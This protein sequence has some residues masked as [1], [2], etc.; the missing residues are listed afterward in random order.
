MSDSENIQTFGLPL[1]V[2]VEGPNGEPITFRASPKPDDFDSI[3]DDPKAAPKYE[4]PCS[5]C[6]EIHAK[7]GFPLCI[8]IKCGKFSRI[9]WCGQCV[10]CFFKVLLEKGI[11]E[12]SALAAIDAMSPGFAAYTQKRKHELAKVNKMPWES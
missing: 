6:H 3:R 5:I 7:E 2:T 4:S 9:V 8:C 10:E 11:E 12:P 1:E